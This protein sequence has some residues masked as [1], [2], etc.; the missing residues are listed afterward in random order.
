L[1]DIH[2]HVRET[3]RQTDTQTHREITVRALRLHIGMRIIKTQFC[4]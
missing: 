1:I 3:D 4:I 2:H